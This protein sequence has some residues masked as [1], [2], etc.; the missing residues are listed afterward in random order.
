MTVVVEGGG[1]GEKLVIYKYKKRKN[2]RRRTGHRQSY[3]LLRVQE[4]ARA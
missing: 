1:R 4:I 3:T 2:Y